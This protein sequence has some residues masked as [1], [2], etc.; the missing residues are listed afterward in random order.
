M[1]TEEKMFKQQYNW[2]KIA[3]KLIPKPPMMKA[4]TFMSVMGPE[5]I[6]IYNTF[7]IKCN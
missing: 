2:F 5:A 1:A 4:S 6:N 3:T 7:Y